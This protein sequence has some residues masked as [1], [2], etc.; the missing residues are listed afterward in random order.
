MCYKN[1]R[2]L[3]AWVCGPGQ[4]WC[5]PI[6]C[7]FSVAFDFGRDYD[8]Q[9]LASPGPVPKVLS[10]RADSKFIGCLGAPAGG[11]AAP[12]WVGL[13]QSAGNTQAQRGL[14]EAR[15]PQTQQGGPMARPRAHRPLSWRKVFRAPALILPGWTYAMS[16]TGWDSL[17][18][19]EGNFI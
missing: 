14:W 5:H 9:V 4:M 8:T 7:S 1:L 6:G 17:N 12:S 19:R 16:N 10:L 15:S 11:P 18:H 13:L 2:Y 3:S